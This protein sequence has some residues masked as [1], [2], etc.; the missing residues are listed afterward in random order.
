MAVL[1]A[2]CK[3]ERFEARISSAQKDLLLQAASLRFQ[4]LT[5]FV[6][7]SAHDA[8][9]ETITKHELMTLCERDSQAFVQALINPPAPAK[10]LREAARRYK[11]L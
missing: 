5:E 6:L 10:K 9:V 1:T 4:N 8:A 7:T 3:M 2:E 11:Q